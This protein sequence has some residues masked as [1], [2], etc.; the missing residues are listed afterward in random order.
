[1]RLNIPTKLYIWLRGSIS[2]ASSEIWF[3]KWG[4]CIRCCYNQ[5]LRFILI[6]LP[7][8]TSKS[9]AYTWWHI[10]KSLYYITNPCIVRPKSDRKQI[11]WFR[12]SGLKNKRTER[13]AN[14]LYCWLGYAFFWGSCTRSSTRGQIQKTFYL[15]QWALFRS[16]LNSFPMKNVVELAMVGV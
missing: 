6:R 8:I 1:M 16:M 11:R 3:T 14:M 4:T 13:G 5:G 15:E 2:Q 10:L 7:M 9:L 12:L